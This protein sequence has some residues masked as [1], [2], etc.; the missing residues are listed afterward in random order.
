M[1]SKGLTLSLPEEKTEAIVNACETAMLKARVSVRELA[2][3]IGRMSTAMLAILPAPLCYRGLQALKIRSLA[4]SQ[5]FET[6]VDLDRASLEEL[7]WWTIEGRKW[8]GRSILPQTDASLLGWGAVSGSSTGGLWSEAERTRHINLL[9]LTG[10]AFATQAF[11]K[12]QR[13]IHIL[14]RMDNTTAT[15]Y[16][17]HMGGTR[18]QDLSHAACELWQWCLQRGIT[19]AA[20]HLPGVCNVVADQESGMDVGRQGVQ[21]NSLSPGAAH[22]RFVCLPAEQPAGEVCQLA[23]G[24][25]YSANRRLSDVVEGEDRICLPPLQSDRQMPPEGVAGGLHSDSSCADMENTA[26]VPS[27]PG[28]AGGISSP[29]TNIQVS[30]EGSIQQGSPLTRKKAVAVSRLESLRQH[31]ATGGI[32][33]KASRLLLSGWSKGT[34]ATYQSGWSKWAGW[35]DSREIDSISC[36]VKDFLTDLFEQG[37]QHRSINTIRSAVSM[38]HDNI[39]GTPIGQHPL[40]TRLLRGVHNLRPPKPRYEHTWDVDAVTKHIVKMGSNEDLSRKQLSQKL[41][42]L[43]A[44]MEASRTS[45]FRALD[46]RFRIYKPDGVQFRLASLTKKRTPGAPPKVLFFERR[47][48]CV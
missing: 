36:N 22:D 35:C 33:G 3:L 25:I 47:S 4:A 12:N 19:I 34:N 41:A 39:E 30:T 37:M 13:N 9:E 20:E 44:L 18:S 11:T 5:S 2:G 24:S 46:L 21:K 26:L 43:M 10:G 42:V 16:I 6:E 8:N 40:V 1:D 31:Q 27:T 48:G 23:A 28:D 15:S 45:E 7:R 14:L 32:S 38:T 29:V 17:N